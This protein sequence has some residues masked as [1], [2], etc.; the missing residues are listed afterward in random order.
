MNPLGAVLAGGRGS[1][2]GGRKA[3]AEVLGRPLLD[4]TLEALRRSVEDVVVIAKVATPLPPTDAPVWRS[5]PPD[6]HPR[7]GLISAL[8]GARGRPVVVV[9]VDMPLVPEALIETLLALVD[10]GALAAIPEAGGHIHPLCAAYHPA[11]L[12]PLESADHDEP[13]K[14]TLDGLGAAVVSAEHMGGRLLNINTP[15]DLQ[16]AER[17]LGERDSLRVAWEEHAA[18]WIAWA[19]DYELDHFFWRFNLPRFLELVPEPGRLTVDLGCGEGRMARELQLAGH[20]VVG[21]DTSPTLAEAARTAEPPTQVLVADAAEV[22]LDDGVAD[23]VLAFMSLMNVDD[24]D[25]VVAEAARLLEPGGRLCFAVVHPAK[26]VADARGAYFQQAPY[27]TTSER[28]GRSMRFHEMH[29]PLEAFTRA[30]ERAGLLIET[31]REPVP[32]DEHVA[33]H[34]EMERWRREPCFLHGRAVKRA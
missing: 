3:T 14:R 33:A 25:A 9:P 20:T 21:I 15:A 22:P 30:L 7:H 16:V 13:L 26:S 24:L 12:G 19:R 27:T 34:P 4:W 10:D 6:F 8:R 29:H 5:E 11:A 32:D 18:D 31:L 2:L 23:L 17:M 1:R 28:G